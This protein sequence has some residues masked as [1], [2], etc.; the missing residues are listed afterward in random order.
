MF[1]PGAE[2]RAF[3][4]ATGR[5]LWALPSDS[6]FASAEGTADATRAFT[7]TLTSVSAV[8]AATG[9]L[10]WKRGISGDGWVG[11]RMRSLTLS[12]EGDLLVATEGLFN[13]NGF[14]SAAAIVAL[15]P[16]TG[17]ERWRYQDGG[18]T[19][20]RSIGGLTLWENLMLYTDGTGGEVVAV[21]RA[22]REV[23]WRRAWLP[24]FLGRLRAPVVVDGVAYWGAGD[25]RVYAADARTGA[26]VWTAGSG[27]GSL[28]NHDVCGPY[29][30]ST[31][32][33][34]KVNRREGGRYEGNRFGNERVGQM[35][36]ADGVAYVS[37]ERG[38]YALACE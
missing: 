14:F 6:S 26:E 9:Q 1:C 2:L 33:S 30:L 36:V 27:R 12:P 17:V 38:V 5:L 4:A 10:L 16:A 23:V 3:D 13:E 28:R 15:D 11:S 31:S 35:A 21:N 24:G 20:D 19:T 34:L 32:S 7:A 22:T 18:P 25:E 29:V 8:D 37:T